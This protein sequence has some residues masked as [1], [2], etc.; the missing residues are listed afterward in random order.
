MKTRLM[1]YWRMNGSILRIPEIDEAIDD[2]TEHGP[3]QHA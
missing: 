3:P 2:L 1:I